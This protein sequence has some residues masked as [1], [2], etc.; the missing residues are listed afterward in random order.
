MLFIRI[1]SIAQKNIR[2][3]SAYSE[4]VN[5]HLHAYPYPC[6]N[7]MGFSF[8]KKDVFTGVAPIMDLDIC[9]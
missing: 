4:V 6:F 5:N 7:I 9:K 1:G 2:M 8:L 3:F